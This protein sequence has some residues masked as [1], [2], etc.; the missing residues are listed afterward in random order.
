MSLNFNIALFLLF[1]SIFSG[2]IY[3]AFFSFGNGVYSHQKLQCGRQIYL[4]DRTNQDEQL[5]NFVKG[6]IPVFF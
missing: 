4:A 5:T 3:Q 6:T 2:N 1:I